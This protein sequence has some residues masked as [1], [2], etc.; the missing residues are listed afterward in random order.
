MCALDWPSTPNWG[1]A[2]LM[3]LMQLIARV[4]AM[5]NG[6]YN[7]IRTVHAHHPRRGSPQ[8]GINE[9]LYLRNAAS[10]MAPPMPTG[11]QPNPYL[12]QAVRSQG[13]SPFCAF[14]PN[15]LNVGTPERPPIS[16]RHG[17]WHDEILRPTHV[18]EH[19]HAHHA[20]PPSAHAW[21]SVLKRPNPVKRRPGCPFAINCQHAF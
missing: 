18:R 4:S 15:T 1:C 16:D 2:S 13:P 19:E 7:A 21:H 20:T 14:V 11:C 17:S 8:N 5:Y 9:I 12:Y 3:P 10:A 6:G